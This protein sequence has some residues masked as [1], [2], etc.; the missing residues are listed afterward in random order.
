MIK[1]QIPGREELT[2]SGDY[3][4]ILLDEAGNYTNYAFTIQVY[5]DRNSG[6]FFALVLLVICG[7]GIYLLRERKR[8]RV[9]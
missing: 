2:L 4:I 8:V 5:F 6:I 9:R 7:T 1:I 3:K